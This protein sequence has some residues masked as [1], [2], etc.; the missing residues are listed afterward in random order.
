MKAL[1][2]L[3]YGSAVISALLATSLDADAQNGSYRNAASDTIKSHYADTVRQPQGY[4]IYRFVDK[5]G[6]CGIVVFSDYWHEPRTEYYNGGGYSS[7]IA[8]KSGERV[9]NV[10]A[11]GMARNRLAE[12]MKIVDEKAGNDFKANAV[13]FSNQEFKKIVKDYVPENSTTA[14]MVGKDKDTGELIFREKEYGEA[15]VVFSHFGGRR[16]KK[17]AEHLCG[18]LDDFDFSPYVK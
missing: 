9:L 2:G 14:V 13:V 18:E 8:K 12:W 7:G 10:Q 3:F 17:I 5:D 4:G 16:Y 15:I 1:N 11:I 6:R